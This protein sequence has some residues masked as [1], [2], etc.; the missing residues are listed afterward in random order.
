MIAG[1]MAS[2]YASC[3]KHA[4]DQITRLLEDNGNYSCIH[5]N[6]ELLIYIYIYIYIS[7]C[8]YAD[9]FIYTYILLSY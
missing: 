4:D 9:T 6:S 2:W 5:T 1:H 3:G 8:I 7:I